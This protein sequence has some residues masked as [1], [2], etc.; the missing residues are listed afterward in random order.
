MEDI[1]IIWLVINLF[2]SGLAIAIKIGWLWIIAG[3][4]WSTFSM[5]IILP[6]SIPLALISLGI[7]LFQ[8]IYGFNEVF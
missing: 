3:L 5:V 6:E 8:M 7:G 1:T 4:T 2:V